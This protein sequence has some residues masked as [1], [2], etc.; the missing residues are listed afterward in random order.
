MIR[1]SF[2]TRKAVLPQL[3]QIGSPQ[4]LPVLFL[5]REG[6][7]WTPYSFFHFPPHSIVHKLKTK[8]QAPNEFFSPRRVE[9]PYAY[10]HI[11]KRFHRLSILSDSQKTPYILGTEKSCAP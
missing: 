7:R 10:S 2:C 5:T 9:L 1:N 11:P 4:K 3:P 6:P 8:N